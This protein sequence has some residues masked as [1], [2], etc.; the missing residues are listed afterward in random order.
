MQPQG[1]ELV[2]VEVLG[3]MPWDGAG[4]HW[5]R[6]G[7]IPLRESPRRLVGGKQRVGPRGTGMDSGS[8]QFQ[9]ETRQAGQ[10]RRRAG[11]QGWK[12]P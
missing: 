11:I 2:Q 8:R 5:R 4:K 1:T 9:Q 7:L 6:N 10:G 12:R 3:T